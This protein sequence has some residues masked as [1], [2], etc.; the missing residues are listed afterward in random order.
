M[1][2]VALPLLIV[3]DGSVNKADL[4]YQFMKTHVVVGAE[5]RGG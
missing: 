3:A 2:P 4:V 5:R 1:I